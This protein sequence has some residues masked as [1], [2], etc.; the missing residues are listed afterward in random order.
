[1]KTLKT[2]TRIVESIN[3]DLI[4]KAGKKIPNKRDRKISIYN[5]IDEDEDNIEVDNLFD[6]DLDA[7]DGDG[8]LDY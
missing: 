5:P 1:M 3:D 8:D 6:Y 2:K 7:I 4:R